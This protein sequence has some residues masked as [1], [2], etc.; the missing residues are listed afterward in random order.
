MGRRR[1]SWDEAKIQR[2]I[3]E[4]RGKG[5][6]SE[7]KPWLTIQDVPSQ[8][9][10]TR[11]PGWKTDRIHHL[12]SDHETRFF[13]LL[14]LSDYV[15]DIREQFPLLER[16]VTQEI[17]KD[18]GVKHPVDASTQTP[19]VLTTDFMIS[20]VSG[21]AKAID[22]ARTVKPSD[23]LNDLRIIEIF[24]I[25]RRYYTAKGID[26]AIVTEIDIPLILAKN[27]EAIH[28]DYWLEATQE[29]DLAHLRS[30]AVKLK[31]RLKSS[32]ASITHITDGLDEEQNLSPGTSLRV[33][34]HLLARKEVIVDM[35]KKLNFSQSAQSIKKIFFEH[36]GEEA[37]A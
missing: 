23:K 34:K 11:A 19:L 32:S 14:E 7:Y 8:G 26:W 15:I 17:A 12:L 24:E 5:R 36:S 6:G 18:M 33:F 2:Y 37:S 21:G 25:E 4:G 31:N 27:I 28:Q 22:I 30:L 35:D 3:K 9:R 16:D 1:Y 10:V 29:L 13:Y 20:I